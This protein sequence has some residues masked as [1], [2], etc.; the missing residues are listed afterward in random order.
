MDGL[1]EF[2]CGK[3][4]ASL[5]QAIPPLSVVASTWSCVILLTCKQIPVLL[6]TEVNQEVHC[7]TQGQG[8]V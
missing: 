6:N 2:E 1:S 5:E 4:L 8:Q 7:R 3:G